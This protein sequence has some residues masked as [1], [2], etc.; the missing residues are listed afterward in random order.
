MI[1][2]ILKIIL[3]SSKYQGISNES[4]DKDLINKWYSKRKEVV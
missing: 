4:D 1:E 3:I 2:Q